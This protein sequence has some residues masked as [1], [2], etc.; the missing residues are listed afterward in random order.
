LSYYSPTRDESVEME[1]ALKAG[2]V[3]EPDSGM[4]FC[5]RVI[6]GVDANKV[7]TSAL[8]MNGLLPS[9]EYVVEDMSAGVA[10]RS[11]SC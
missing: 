7:N 3:V 11:G 9:L 8:R 6:E 4:Q 5:A 2:Q 10:E 1:E